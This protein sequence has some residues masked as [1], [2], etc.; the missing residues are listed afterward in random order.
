MKN[1][2]LILFLSIAIVLSC[3]IGGSIA[4]LTSM[5]K[6]VVNTFTYGDINITL[7][8]TT[9]EYKMIPGQVVAKDPKVTVLAG[10]EDCW[11]FVKLEKSANYDDYLEAPVITNGWTQGTGTI[12]ENVYYR[13]VT[14]HDTNDQAFP[15]LQDNVITVLSSVTKEDMMKLADGTK[16]TLIFTGYAVQ[17]VGFDTA[18]LAWDEIGK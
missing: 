17:K 14:N 3:T 10:S 2:Y 15:V 9:T 6:P 1:K 8:E 18:Q 7:T 11:L 4:W 5:T 12:P 16:P 13:E